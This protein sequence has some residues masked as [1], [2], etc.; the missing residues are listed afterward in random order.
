[1]CLLSGS[2]GT[3]YNICL[4][5]SN[6]KFRVNVLTRR[7]EIFA[8]KTVKGVYDSDG[9]V[10]EGSIAKVSSNPADVCSGTKIYIV[11]A[12]VNVQEEILHS[13]KPY[14]EHGSIIGSVYGQ[15][16]FDLIAESVFGDDI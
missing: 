16:G 1:M 9:R 12:P 2:Q 13:I 8:S 3:H 11:S 5:G 6:P 4:A 15:G 7:P 10:I 14:V